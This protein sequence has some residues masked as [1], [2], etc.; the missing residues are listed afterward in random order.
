MTNFQDK[1]TFVFVVSESNIV[2]KIVYFNKSEKMKDINCVILRFLEYFLD[3][4]FSRFDTFISA[5]VII[6]ERF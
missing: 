1:T 3:V 5:R 4:F 6:L 2:P